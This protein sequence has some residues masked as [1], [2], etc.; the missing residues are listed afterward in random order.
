[1]VGFLSIAMLPSRKSVI[2]RRPGPDPEAARISRRGYV[3]RVGVEIVQ[4]REEGTIRPPP[5]QPVEEGFV[6]PA[7]TAGL[8][9]DPLHVVIVAAIQDVLED[10]VPGNRAT[11]EGPRQSAG[12]PRNG[13]SREPAR[14]RNCS[15]WCS[16]RTRRSDSPA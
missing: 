6:D 3:R 2:P 7:R 4:E 15:S 9:A 11:E 14:S 10:P 1:M 13:R 12:N 16:P 8:E 5:A